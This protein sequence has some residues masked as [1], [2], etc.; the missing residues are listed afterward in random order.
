MSTTTV[1][2]VF[3]ASYKGDENTQLAAKILKRA[4]AG[5][6]VVD[7][8]GDLLITHHNSDE[9]KIS[10]GDLRGVVLHKERGVV[11]R[12]FGYTPIAVQS[13]VTEVDGV[14]TVKD[15]AGMTH[16][17]PSEGREVHS[18]LD[19]MMLRFCWIDGELVPFSH[20]RLDIK[21]SRWGSSKP[22]IAMYN[23]AGGPSA[24]EMFDVTV[25]N[26]STVYFFMVVDPALLVGTRQRVTVPYIVYLGN[27]ENDLNGPDVAPGR[28]TFKTIEKISGLVTKSVVVA[29][30]SMTVEEANNHLAFGYYRPHAAVDP[31]LL[32]GEGVIIYRKENGQIKDAVRVHSPAYEWRAGLGGNNPNKP[33]QFYCLI[34]KA[35]PEITTDAA[36]ALYQKN[37]IMF[38]EYEPSALV[39][40]YERDGMILTLPVQ[41]ANRED[42]T[43]RQV[44]IHNMWINYVV[45]LP[46]NHQKE[47]L[48]IF[49]KFLAD[50]ASVTE[51]IQ[52]IERHNR[53]INSTQYPDRVKGIVS[54][55]RKLA[56]DRMMAGDNFGN[57][58]Q[59]LP[60]P[61]VIKI[62]VKNLV[63]KESGTSLYSLVREWR[64]STKEETKESDS[65]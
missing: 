1:P 38:P 57:K 58:G 16:V 25:P 53:D 46:P 51:W 40:M 44:R 34:N 49:G 10:C 31:R 37:F 4:P 12:S 65:Q 17:F 59:S 18:V 50:R 60:L 9:S 13:S 56:R 61:T 3:D 48:E 20:R 47:G 26:S 19:G 55:S 14:I 7:V 5:W 28:P 6:S 63:N 11:A 41:E 54:I 33:N 22:F 29:P 24:E 42:Y 21:K 39:E 62:V 36:W 35:N 23:E 30:K 2:F 27:Q 15:Q 43:D 8:R 32:T 52:E 64:K 45:S